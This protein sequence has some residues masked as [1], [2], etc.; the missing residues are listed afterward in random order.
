M[1][2]LSSGTGGGGRGGL[3]ADADAAADGAADVVVDAADIQETIK[4]KKL[5]SQ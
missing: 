4:I 5:L 1:V 2:W 3:A